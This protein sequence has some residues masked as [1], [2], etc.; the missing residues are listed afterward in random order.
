MKAVQ[1]LPES[2]PISQN[3]PVHP[4]GHVLPLPDSK[5]KGD[6]GGQELVRQLNPLKMH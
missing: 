1:A 3:L 6:S 2:L 4:T 5:Q